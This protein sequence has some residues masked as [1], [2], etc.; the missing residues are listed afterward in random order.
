M[1]LWF[2][3]ARRYLSELITWLRRGPLI[4]AVIAAI[5]VLVIFMGI[6]CLERQIRISGMALQLM[7]VILVAVGL[8]DTR[9]AF[10]DLPTTLGAIKAWRSG[11][12][13]FGPQH[14]VLHAEGA[15]F[16][17]STVAARARVSAG[18][19]SPLERRVAILEQEV[20]NLF[21]ELGTLSAEMKKKTDEGSERA[22]AD[23]KTKNQLR[24]AIAE[25][26]PL[27]IVGVIFFLLGITGGTASPEIASSFGAGACQ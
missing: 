16:G 22:K 7:G 9:Q 19:D 8:R 11:R 2:G 23:E 27:G 14:H 15:S 3:W 25:G 4:A 21:D 20:T 26:I 12:L 6:S 17:T 1:F 13:R 24:R 18:P 10:D 5:F